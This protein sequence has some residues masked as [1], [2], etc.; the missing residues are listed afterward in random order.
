VKPFDFPLLTDE[1]VHPQVVEALRKAGHDVQTI[2]DL[3]L[4][5]TSD[6]ELLRRAHVEGR[7]VLT[8]DADFGKLALVDREP[9]TGIV[10]LRPGH[11]IAAFVLETIAAVETS[12]HDVMPP[13]ILVAERRG[14]HV[15]IRARSATA[16]DRT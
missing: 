2:H 16:A 6:R 8:H 14:D 13:F 3:A 15:R 5:G 1:N 11:I 12:S 10:Y 4:A 9:F 7:V